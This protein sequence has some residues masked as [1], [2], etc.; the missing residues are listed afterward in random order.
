M[1][2]LAYSTTNSWDRR[3][4]CQRLTDTE[5]ISNSLD[6]PFQR[7]ISNGTARS[8]STCLFTYPT[9]KIIP[10]TLPKIEQE[11]KAVLSP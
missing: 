6:N 7:L 5:L 2:W 1:L 10:L 8:C 9:R 4:E 11:E 3:L